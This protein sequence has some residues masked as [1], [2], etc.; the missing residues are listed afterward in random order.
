MGGRAVPNEFIQILIQLPIVGLFMWYS[1]RKDRQF[2][3]FLREERQSRQMQ[4]NELGAEIRSLRPSD[5]RGEK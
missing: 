2:M 3:D 1:E 5:L 4:L